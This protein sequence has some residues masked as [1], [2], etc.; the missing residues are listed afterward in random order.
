[1]L[2]F[3]HACTRISALGGYGMGTVL[4]KSVG[5]TECL[6]SVRG[7]SL[8]PYCDGEIMDFR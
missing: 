3:E 8:Y 1:M 5:F 6:R 4:V 7:A 2:V